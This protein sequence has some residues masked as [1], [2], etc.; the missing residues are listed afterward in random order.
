MEMMSSTFSPIPLGW[1]SSDSIPVCSWSLRAW[2]KCS[3]IL[4][5]K[6]VAS[7]H[8]QHLSTCRGLM[9]SK[10]WPPW[11][12]H[13]GSGSG[14]MPSSEVNLELKLRCAPG[15]RGWGVQQTLGREDR[16]AR[17]QAPASASVA[18]SSTLGVFVSLKESEYESTLKQ[19]HK[20]DQSSCNDTGGGSFSWETSE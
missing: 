17:P 14:H 10:S 15:A 20:G 6:T 2:I 11:S 12:P 7:H 8:S 19:N 1:V 3:P 18:H 5:E 9:A 4:V 16:P 13:R